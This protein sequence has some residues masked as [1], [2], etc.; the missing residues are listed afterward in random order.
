MDPSAGVSP[1][2]VQHTEQ[3][4]RL[5][6]LLQRKIAFAPSKLPPFDKARWRKAL[7]LVVKATMCCAEEEVKQLRGLADELEKEEQAEAAQMAQAAEL[8]APIPPTSTYPLNATTTLELTSY[9]DPSTPSA[10]TSFQNAEFDPLAPFNT[11][12]DYDDF[13]RSLGL[14]PPTPLPMDFLQ[15]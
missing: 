14:V 13:F 11:T 5:I 2:V 10:G 6:D 3:G 7:D 4:L 15:S 12:A 9:S 8:A 1:L